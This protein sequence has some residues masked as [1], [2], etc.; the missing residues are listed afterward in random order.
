MSTLFGETFAAVRAKRRMSLGEFDGVS[1]SYLYGIERKDVL[2]APERLDLL[3]GRIG[4]VAA[5]QRVE[6]EYIEKEELE[7]RHAWWGSQLIRL[8]AEPELASVTATLLL[9]SPDEQSIIAQAMDAV[10]AGQPK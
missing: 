10:I 1:G 6:D 3:V 5:E 9:A 7:L 2:P 8:G 4:E